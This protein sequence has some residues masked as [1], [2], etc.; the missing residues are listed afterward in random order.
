MFKIWA[1][2]IKEEKIVK[3]VMYINESNYN[4]K[5][6]HTYLSEICKESD[7]ETPILLTQHVHNFEEFNSVKFLKEDFLEEINFNYLVLENIA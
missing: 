1:R 5:Q 4:R 7:L 3:D 6:F 2:V